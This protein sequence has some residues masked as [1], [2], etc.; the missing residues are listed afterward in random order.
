MFTIAT[1]EYECTKKCKIHGNRVTAAVTKRSVT[2]EDLAAYIA[3]LCRN[4]AEIVDDEGRSALAMA[5][6]VGNRCDL[7]AWL[8][9]NGANINLKDRESG[10][11]PLVRAIYYGNIAEAVMLQIRGAT[12][13]PDNDFVNPLQYCCRVKKPIEQ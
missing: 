10:H 3:K 11:T 5:V 2:S 6:S 7:L 9:Q 4:F 1:Y 13:V 8:V 12:L